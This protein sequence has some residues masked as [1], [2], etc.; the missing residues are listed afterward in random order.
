MAFCVPRRIAKRYLN[1]R[2]IAGNHNEGDVVGKDKAA[3]HYEVS[4]ELWHRSALRL[5]MSTYMGG[6]T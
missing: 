6:S 3:Y 4:S 2:F 5:I 1:R